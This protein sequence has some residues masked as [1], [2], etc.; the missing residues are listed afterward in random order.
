MLAGLPEFAPVRIL[1]RHILGWVDRCNGRTVRLTVRLAESHPTRS[2]PSDSRRQ[3][4]PTNNRAA[5]ER[6]GSRASRRSHTADRGIPKAG[7]HL[8]A[9]V[10]ARWPS[11]RGRR[12]RAQAA[13]VSDHDHDHDHSILDRGPIPD[14]DFP[15]CRSCHAGVVRERATMPAYPRLSATREICG[16]CS[17][18]ISCETS[19]FEGCGGTQTG[20]PGLNP[21][22]SYVSGQQ[23]CGAQKNLD[24]FWRRRWV[25]FRDLSS[26]Q[27][28]IAYP[29]PGVRN[30]KRLHTPENAFANPQSLPIPA[31][32]PISSC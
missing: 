25:I 11:C 13:S 3:C 9:S 28:K 15:L 22:G 24:D 12:D 7:D 26:G 21:S 32:G 16:I 8:C 31:I 20:Q 29:L 2:A 10:L 27:Q 14:R 18:P 19:R 17:L 30:R 5:A 1:P 4:R 6:A 23:P